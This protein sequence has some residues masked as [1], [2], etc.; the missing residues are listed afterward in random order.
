MIINALLLFLTFLWDFF[1]SCP[2]NYRNWSLYYKFV[3]VSHQLSSVALSCPTLCNPMDCSTPGLPVYHQLPEFTQTHV[4]WIGDAIQPSHPHAQG[5]VSHQT[6]SKIKQF[7]LMS[8]LFNFNRN[9][10]IM[11][12][13]KKEY[14]C[15]SSHPKK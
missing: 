3:T 5:T 8:H 9:V 2:E 12:C 4:H 13:T 10:K 6:N 15:F 11:M 1:L 7:A 14:L